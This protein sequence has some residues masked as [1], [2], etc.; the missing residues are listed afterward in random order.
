[1]LSDNLVLDVIS[2][3]MASLLQL[4]WYGSI[5]AEHPTIMFYYV[6]K[7]LSEIYTLQEYQTISGKV[8]KSGEPV[9]K[10]EYIS[11]LESKTNWYFQQLT[12]TEF[13][14]IN[15]YH[16]SYMSIGVRYKTYCRHSQEYM[17]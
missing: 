4:V 8:S 15:R 9:V 13:H 1:M 11:I 12:E 3:D 16:F 6:I 5:N 2:D 10:S 14:N 7:Y 17:Q